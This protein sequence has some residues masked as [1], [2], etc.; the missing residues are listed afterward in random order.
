MDLLDHDDVDH[1]DIEAQEERL[2]QEDLEECVGFWAR[3]GKRTRER[4]LLIANKICR[5]RVIR[6]NKLT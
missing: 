2:K 6:G 1:D 5:E 3:R 4:N